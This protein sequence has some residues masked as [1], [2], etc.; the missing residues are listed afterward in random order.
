[1]IL[2]TGAFT[3]ITV[4][5]NTTV[6]L[7]LQFEPANG[8][9]YGTP[10]TPGSYAFTMVVRDSNIPSAQESRNYTIV[11][12]GA[13]GPIVIQPPSETLLRGKVGVPYSQEIHATGGLR[14]YT[15]SVDGQ[16]PPG[17]ALDRTNC[18]LQ[19]APAAS[20]AGSLREMAE[21]AE[22]ALQETN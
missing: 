3:G 15:C 1:L 19:G 14:P 2:L 16:L 5:R 9:I 10:T 12:N 21:L 4:A 13:P 7:E 6:Y 8:R 11:V 22:R 18:V 17:I 20:G